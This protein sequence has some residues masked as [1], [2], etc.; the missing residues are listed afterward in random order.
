M[1]KFNDAQ[2][3]ML[4]AVLTKDQ[5]EI[6]KEK[7]QPAMRPQRQGGGGPPGGGN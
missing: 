7:I 4:K 5:Y 1:K 3:E 6:W 2:N